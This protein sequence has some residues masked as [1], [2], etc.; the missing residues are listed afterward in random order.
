MQTCAGPGLRIESNTA[1]GVVR[2]FSN[3]SEFVGVQL[4]SYST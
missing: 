4:E 2:L 3:G 1:T